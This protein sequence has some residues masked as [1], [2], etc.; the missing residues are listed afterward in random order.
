[1]NSRYRPTDPHTQDARTRIAALQDEAAWKP[2]PGGNSQDS[3]QAYLQAEP[4][5]SYA[6]AAR[7]ELTG[8]DRGRVEDRSIEW[9]GSGFA[10]IPSK[11]PSRG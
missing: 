2:G 6:R 9:I 3:Y 10:S 7:D 1:M 5:G 4:N 11:I 8:V